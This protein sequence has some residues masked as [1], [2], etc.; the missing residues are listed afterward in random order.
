[1]KRDCH[2]STRPRLLL[3]ILVGVVA[4]FSACASIGRP[5]GGALDETPPVFVRSNPSPGALRV[6]NNKI[7]IFFNENIKLEDPGNRIVISPAQ[8]Q[9]P[10]IS[11]N[12]KKVSIELRDTM[13]ENTTYTIDLADAVRDLNE[14]N[15]L[16]GFA[17][18]F[19]T[20][21]SIDSLRISGMVFEAESLEPAQ[22]ML[23]GVY[24]NLDDS[25]ITTLPLLRIA[26]TN[27]Y[28]QF[29]IR[30]LKPGNY[31]IFAINDVNRDYKWDRSE[32]IAF[33][34]QTISPSVETITVTDT[35]RAADGSD[36]I[37]SHPGIRYLPN[38]I[39]LT[40]FNQGYLPQ[41][42][43]DYA[44]PDS[45]R[46]TIT[47]AAP[48][49]SLPQLTI[50][51]GPLDGRRI[52]IAGASRL[53]HSAKLDSLEFWLTDPEIIATDSL[54]VALRYLKT[55]TLDSLSWTTDTLRFNYKAPKVDTKALEKAQKEKERKRAKMLEQGDTA[56]VARMDSLDAIPKIDF[57]QVNI[58]GSTQEVNRPV[59]IKFSQ[60]IAKLSPLAWHLEQK[61]DTTWSP[62]PAPTLIPDSTGNILNYSIPGPWTPGAEYRLTVDS[63]SV[64]NIYGIFNKPIEHSFKVRPAE[65]YSTITLNI[66][67][68]PDSARMVVQLL[69][70]S[71]TPVST[72]V[73]NDRGTATFRYIQ[74]GTYFVRAFVDSNN[75]NLWTTGDI[76][77]HRLP[78]DVYYYPKKINLKKN[79]DITNDWD[80][81]DTPV[82]LQKPNA[83]KK[84]KPKTKEKNRSDQDEF[85][86]DDEDMRDQMGRPGYD[87][88]NPFDNRSNRRGNNNSLRGGSNLQLERTRM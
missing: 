32:D 50:V 64:F 59:E 46:I 43:K 39:L 60:P 31:H 16:D 33:Y 8:K 62:L 70:K 21:D 58:G 9:A 51:N 37:V 67:G 20:G 25:A 24:D 45:N 74:S 54:Q 27:Q 30:N 26:K 42:L 82:D 85:D 87:N 88:R 73:T 76:P 56:G 38:D 52:D 47:M 80:L 81:N 34:P 13:L 48:A 14:G 65:E 17:L 35:L 86:E 11:S 10:K 1:M 84:N 69:S 77:F 29:T 53:K 78:E 19:A 79:W 57:L 63:A 71:D 66:K 2:S 22:G 23:V 6:N 75:D 18:D 28:G 68:I 4:L 12:A 55:D 7:D 83:I 44:R 72:A 49:D 41:Y 3:P 36:S 5:A 40:W 15:I 61:T